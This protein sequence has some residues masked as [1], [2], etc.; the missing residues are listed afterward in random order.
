[1]R[2]PL[3]KVVD[4][5]L[6]V[7]LMLIFPFLYL[8]E[9]GVRRSFWLC[10]ERAAAI[11][12]IMQTEG[13]FSASMLRQLRQLEEELAMNGRLT[14]DIYYLEGELRIL[15]EEELL[16]EHGV[17]YRGECII[18]FS[19]GALLEIRCKRSFDALEKAYYVCCLSTDQE[20]SS[21]E[22]RVI[23]DGLRQRYGEGNEAISLYNTF[24]HTVFLPC[25]ASKTAGQN[26]QAE[27]QPQT[28][29]GTKLGKCSRCCSWRDDFSG[30]WKSYS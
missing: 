9:Q 2:T 12:E 27:Q 13:F 28:V 17:E 29:A 23:R 4:I 11:A 3:S 22:Y 1:M 5:T 26:R 8:H 21:L 6:A 30:G 25:D 10:R 15:L 14:I 16:R 20:H 7:L 24:Y 19:S 18:P